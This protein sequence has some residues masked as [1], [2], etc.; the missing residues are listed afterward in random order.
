MS[1]IRCGA[2][3]IS[4]AARDSAQIDLE[5][6]TAKGEGGSVTLA[7]SDP[8]P[9]DNTR[10]FTAQARAS[11]RVIVVGDSQKNY[12]VAVAFSAASSARW[13]P[14]TTTTGETAT[15]DGL[16]SADVI[17]IN[18]LGRQSSPLEVLRQGRAFAQKII[19]LA[20][21]GDETEFAQSAAFIARALPT[22]IRLR[23]VS[24]TE[25]VTIVLPDT[26]SEIW[27][28]FPRL[29]ATE[30]AIYRYVEGLPGTALLRLSNG[31]PFVTRFTDRDGRIWILASTP[32][33]ITDA[34]NLCE[35]GFFVPCLDRILRYAAADKFPAADPWIAGAP[36][37]N[38]FYGTGKGAAVVRSDGVALPRWQS[39]PMVVVPEPGLYRIT[40]DGADAFWIAVNP[41]PAESR[42]E[43]ALPRV[44]AAGR[45]TMNV[46]SEQ[47]ILDV[48]HNHGRMPSYIPWIVLWLFLLAELLLW[49]RPQT[50]LD[51]T[52]PKRTGG[53]I[54]LHSA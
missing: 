26:I 9:F 32:V 24:V 2:K 40:P 52:N 31:A 1:S 14:V 19:F 48:V 30:V 18:G 36:R 8:L 16:D 23:T 7:E 49:E 39:Q 38:P 47:Q 44:P 43:Y 54:P 45:S 37:R 6:P 13:N 4:L 10:W 12:P 50:G 53:G 42:L 3:R 15:W 33:G 29:N 46:L 27:R 25:P 17:V 34:N 35:T 41:D 21:G 5:V 28:G 22:A 20:L 51:K 11:S